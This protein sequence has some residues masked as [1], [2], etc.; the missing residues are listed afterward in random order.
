MVE[1]S[2]IARFQA[3]RTLLLSLPRGTNVLEALAEALATNAVGHAWIVGR[4]T[5]E[6]VELRGAAEGERTFATTSRIVSLDGHANPGDG[7]GVLSLSTTV[8]RP[9]PRGP[10]P[11][12]PRTQ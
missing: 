3:R 7:R 1:G 4:G 2:G 8:A 10:D 6:E 12:H 5:F 11:V 9:S